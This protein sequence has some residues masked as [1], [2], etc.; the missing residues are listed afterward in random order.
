MPR[1]KAKRVRGAE[2]AWDSGHS[3]SG[4]R[5]SRGKSGDSGRSGGCKRSGDSG[6]KG[7]I[8]S[9]GGLGVRRAI[10]HG[11]ADRLHSAAIHLLR[12]VRQVDTQSRISPARLS[13]LSVLVFGGPRSLRELADAEQV[14]PPT[15]SK[16]A[17]AL[18]ADGFIVRKGD[19]LDLRT[20][21][22]RATPKGKAI[23]QRARK[24]RI[25]S[26]AALLSSTSKSELAILQQA[27]HIIEQAVNR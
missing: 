5:S 19:R 24:L 2:E 27:A 8:G 11:V 21:Q 12:T 1:L 3:G 14:T 7:S 20:I 17:Q 15:M 6:S 18:E 23:L 10:R 13:A 25:D 9:K 22:L 26:L 16:I 4:I